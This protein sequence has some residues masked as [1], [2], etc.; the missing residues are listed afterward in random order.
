MM[1]GLISSMRKAIMDRLYHKMKRVSRK[2]LAAVDCDGLVDAELTSVLRA[3][4]SPI[5]QS[6]E[7]RRETAVP[8]RSMLKQQSAMAALLRLAA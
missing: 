8:Q 1:E 3:W 4:P 5:L 7:V 2:I 6:Q